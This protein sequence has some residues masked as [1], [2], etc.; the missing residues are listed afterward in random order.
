MQFATQKMP[1][2]LHDMSLPRFDKNFIDMENIEDDNQSN[3]MAQEASNKTTKIQVKGREQGANAYS[4][5]EHIVLLTAISEVEGA[6]NS[7]E[8][9]EEWIEVFEKLEKMGHTKRKS[10]TLHDHFVELYSGFKKAF[11]LR[12]V[13]NAPRQLVNLKAKRKNRIHT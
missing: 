12:I 1:I 13:L 10:K 7:K 6:F 4:A 2:S 5:P 8:S 11:L 3:R 9:S